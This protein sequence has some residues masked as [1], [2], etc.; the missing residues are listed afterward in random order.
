MSMSLNEMSNRSIRR[1]TAKYT[2]VSDNA[3]CD[4]DV[5]FA[6]IQ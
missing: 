1:A 5:S 2:Y 6:S 3:A 4:C